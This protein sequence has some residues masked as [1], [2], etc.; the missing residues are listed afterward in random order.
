M[1]SRIFTTDDINQMSWEEFGSIMET[2]ISK[3][4]LS[5]I[6]FDAVAP[7]LRNGAIPGTVTANKLQIISMLPVQVKYDYENKKPIQLLP[8][9][10]PL[11]DLGES[12][13]ILVTECN[14][15]TGDSA[16]LAANIIK[17]A[18]P[19]A[20]LYYATVTQVYQNDP[21]DLSIFGQVFYGIMTNE[22]FEV[23]E[24]KEKELQL[25]TKITIYPWETIEEELKD[26]NSYFG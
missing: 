10:K 6:V 5:N 3:I 21:I 1:N 4:Q 26:I 2:L 11:K 19:H 8:F 23:N 15:F 24:E 9:E 16:R 17:E 22:N 14:T 25:R 7:I 13:K 12:P 18:Y 20:E